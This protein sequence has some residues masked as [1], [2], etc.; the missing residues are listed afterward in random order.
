MLGET[1]TA[2]RSDRRAVKIMR[3]GRHASPSQVEKVAQQAGKAAPAVAIAGALVAVPTAQQALA[4]PATTAAT[5]A[6][7]AHQAPVTRAGT[8]TLDAFGTRAVTVASTSTARHA[9]TSTY[10][11]VRSGDT[12][13]RI[14]ERFYHNSGAWQFLYHENNK[15]ISNPNL[16]YVGERLYI[17]ATAPAHYKPASYTPRHAKSA[18]RT[19]TTSTIRPTGGTAE[20]GARIVRSSSLRSYSCSALENL[21]VQAGGSPAHARMAAEIARAESGG[22]PNAISPTDD[23]GLWQINAS[24]GSLATLN[25]YQNARSAIILSQNGTNWNPWTTYHIGAYYGQ[26]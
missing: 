24:N 26:C 17:P 20:G 8:A 13:S 11:H 6:A 9:A 25:A 5:A 2:G 4:A 15:A 12:L 19:V 18:P 10:Y 21:W 16:I 23:F 14:A 1:M 7:A 22:N 3:R